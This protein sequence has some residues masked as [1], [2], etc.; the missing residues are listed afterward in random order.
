MVSAWQFNGH[1]DLC[2]LHVNSDFTWSRNGFSILLFSILSHIQVNEAGSTFKR[3][4]SL[5]G[6]LHDQSHNIDAIKAL[7]LNINQIR[8]E[9]GDHVDMQTAQL[10]H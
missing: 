3:N 2:L 8:V 1:N 7:C 6:T 10:V 5:L 4:S 9:T